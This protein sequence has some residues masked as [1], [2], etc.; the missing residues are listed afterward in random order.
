M[1]GEHPIAVEH[2]RRIN[3]LERWRVEADKRFA[4][5]FP[6]ADYI[7][8]CRYHDLMIAQLEESRKL[9]I[10]VKEK[11]ISGLVWFFI[12]GTA[13]AIWHFVVETLRR[14]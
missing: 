7:G 1:N 8:H 13:L 14:S 2:E 4:D 9:R 12:V 6:G 5:A 10:A 11:T 3:T